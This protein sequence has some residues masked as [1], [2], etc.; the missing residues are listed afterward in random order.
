[1]S[2]LR[3]YSYNLV[4]FEVNNFRMNLVGIFYDFITKKYLEL[5]T[6]IYLV[7]E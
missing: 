3:D 6:N 4:R 7:T 1:M 2:C 5:L